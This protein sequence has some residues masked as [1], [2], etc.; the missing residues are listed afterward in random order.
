MDQVTIP[1][2]LAYREQ[3]RHAAI[4]AQSYADRCAARARAERDRMMAVDA[5]LAARAAVG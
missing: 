2:L 3:L 5:E 4:R 1:E